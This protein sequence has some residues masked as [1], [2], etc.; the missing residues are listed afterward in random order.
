[1]SLHCS[2]R[3]SEIRNAVAAVRDGQVELSVTV[4]EQAVNKLFL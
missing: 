2:A 1:M 3:I 4:D